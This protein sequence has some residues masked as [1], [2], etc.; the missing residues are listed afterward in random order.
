MAHS[1]DGN[2]DHADAAEVS[3]LVSE[4][5]DEIGET[6][7]PAE[8]KTLAAELQMLLDDRVAARKPAI[9]N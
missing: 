6:V 8:I 4:L 1:D 2:T 9:E 7:V 3:Q 5:I